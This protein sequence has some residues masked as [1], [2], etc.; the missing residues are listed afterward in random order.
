MIIENCHIIHYTILNFNVC[1]YLAIVAILK[2]SVANIQ[3]FRTRTFFRVSAWEICRE[4]FRIF[5]VLRS[6]REIGLGVA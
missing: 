6:R 5:G 2:N 4:H 3:Y 1:I